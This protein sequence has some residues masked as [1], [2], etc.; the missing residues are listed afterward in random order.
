VFR[1]ISIDQSFLVEVAAASDALIS[2][3]ENI[4]TSMGILDSI[5]AFPIAYVAFLC[6]LARRAIFIRVFNLCDCTEL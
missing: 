5:H 4:D 2:M 3:V 6:E 1:E